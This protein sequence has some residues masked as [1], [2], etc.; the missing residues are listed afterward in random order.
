M[1]R[2]AGSDDAR[3]G[4]RTAGG[5]GTQCAHRAAARSEL[6][7]RAT[8]AALGSGRASG[9]SRP[10][11]RTHTRTPREFGDC[12]CVVSNAVSKAHSRVLGLVARGVTRGVLATCAR[13]NAQ[14]SLHLGLSTRNLGQRAARAVCVPVCPG[15]PVVHSIGVVVCGAE[16]WDLVQ[17]CACARTL[18]AAFLSP[19]LSPPQ[20]FP[21]H[22]NGVLRIRPQLRWRH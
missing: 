13:R 18:C 3:S 19:T 21:S 9:T 10:G 14:R 6:C 8:S 22:T 16:N 2:G 11:P 4:N 1:G 20:R 17:M 12:A 5:T 15:A 7:S